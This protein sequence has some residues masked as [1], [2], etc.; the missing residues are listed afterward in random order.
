MMKLKR[1]FEIAK[2]EGSTV[3]LV[4]GER[5]ASQE[6]FQEALDERKWLDE[7]RNKR[8]PGLDDRKSAYRAPMKKSNFRAPEKMGFQ[9]R[10]SGKKDDLSEKKNEK[11][12][13]IDKNVL[14]TAMTTK[15]ITKLVPNE[16]ILSTDQLNKLY[17]KVLKAR[18][19]KSKK[20]ADL[21]EE[22][23]YEKHRAETQQEVIILPT[24]DV[25]G[26]MVHI[27][28]EERHPKKQRTDTHDSHGNRISYLNED[29]LSLSDL[30]RNEKMNQDMSFDK[31]VAMQISK[32]STFRDNLDYIDEASEKL[33]KKRNYDPKKERDNAI[34]GI[35]DGFFSI[36]ISQSINELKQF[37]NLVITVI[38]MI[39]LQKSQLSQW[40]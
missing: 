36:L 27:N 21:E 5:Y 12:K 20:I 1:V 14:P 18:L 29:H 13:S 35:I 25:D 30:V 9:E 40:D 2:E 7:Q 31:E 6:D 19:M 24:V 34:R 28:N 11:T 33:S 37:L 26:K 38:K 22:Y 16:P 10:Q 23:E 15:T 3:E 32:D 39:G 8:D 4:A 17:S